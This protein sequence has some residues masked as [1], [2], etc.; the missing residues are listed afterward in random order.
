V[1]AEET[2]VSALLDSAALEK[3]PVTPL[4]QK[5]PDCGKPPGQKAL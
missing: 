3:A 2:S 5:P 4:V 1:T